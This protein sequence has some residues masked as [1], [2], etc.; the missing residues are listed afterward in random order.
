MQGQCCKKCAPKLRL[1]S[2]APLL[3]LFHYRRE[4]RTRYPGK[5][6]I[7]AFSKS[8]MLEE[9]LQRAGSVRQQLMQQVPAP[10]QPPS[11]DQA[12]PDPPCPLSP[13]PSSGLECQG[14]HPL[15]PESCL[16]DAA[17][18][19][20]DPSEVAARLP[21]ALAVSSLTEQGIEQLQATIIAMFS[22]QAVRKAHAA[23]EAAAHE[24]LLLDGAGAA[25]GSVVQ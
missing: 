5:P 19:F 10:A 11:R 2:N 22:E 4:L 18:I 12:Q 20:G 9:E 1:L 7:D 6:W 16:G 21:C 13:V 3:C 25:S 15:A 8:D 14:Q 23:L 24:S 17:E